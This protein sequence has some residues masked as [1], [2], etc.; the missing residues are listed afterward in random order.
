MANG[1]WD[2]LRGMRRVEFFAALA[3]A[4][5]LALVLLSAG[6][7]NGVAQKTELEARLERI[8]AQIDGAGK[9]SAMIT[10]NADGKAAGALIVADGLEDV[11]TYLCIQRAVATVLE[12]EPAGIEIV[13]RAGRFGG[14]T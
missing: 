8:L 10:Q 6:R 11:K 9:V 4:A 13:G 1:L 2:R 12:L 7:G 14:G 3:I 5:A